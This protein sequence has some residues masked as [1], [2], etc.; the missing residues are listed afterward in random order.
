MQ[1]QNLYPRWRAARY[2]AAQPVTSAEMDYLYR[3]LDRSYLIDGD[4]FRGTY[5][6]DLVRETCLYVIDEWVAAEG[7]PAKLR[8]LKATDFR[9]L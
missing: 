2:P 1:V 5:R 9:I 8:E 3:C 6:M 7:D 4:P